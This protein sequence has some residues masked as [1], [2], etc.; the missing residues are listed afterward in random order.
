MLNSQTKC[1]IAPEI[2]HLQRKGSSSNPPFFRV[3]VK[4]RGCFL[5][6][7]WRDSLGRLS[8]LGLCFYGT[9]ILLHDVENIILNQT[10]IY[11][12]IYIYNLIKKSCVLLIVTTFL[13]LR[14]YNLRPLRL[15]NPGIL[16]I[17]TRMPRR[18]P[19][20]SGPNGLHGHTPRRL[21]RSRSQRRHQWTLVES[22]KVCPWK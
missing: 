14:L 1:N 6:N 5:L 22:S 20:G 8:V 19:H 15:Q 12:N 11:V 18:Q 4:L 13:K 10:Y 21:S 7:F 3:Y 2:L 16:E 17:P 9:N